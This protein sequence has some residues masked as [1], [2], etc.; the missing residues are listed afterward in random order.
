MAVAR[1]E[2]DAQQLL[3]PVERK[4][5][6]I[7]RVVRGRRVGVRRGPFDHRP[8][9]VGDGKAVGG[10]AVLRNDV[11]RERLAGPWI[12]DDGG[13]RREV[14]VQL[15]QGRHGSPRR[16]LLAIERLDL[17]TA[18]EEQA[19]LEQRAA[20]RAAVVVEV[21]LALDVV[22]VG[23]PCREV[24][25]LVE[26]FVA[27]GI[28][29][30][31]AEPVRAALGHD[32]DR[33]AGVAPLVGGEVRR[34]DGDLLDEVDPDVVDHAAVRPRVE[35]E[36][37]VDGQVVAVAA[38]AVDHG[39]ARAEA[40]G[41]RHLVVVELHGAGNERGQLEIVAARQRRVL[42]LRAVDDARDLSGGAV[43]GLAGYR[44][45]FD[46]LGQAADRQREV[47]GHAAVG[48]HREAALLGLAEAFELRGDLV[49]ANRKVGDGVSAGGRGDIRP[50]DASL[51]VRDGDRH[52]RQHAAGGIAHRS[53]DLSGVGLGQLPAAP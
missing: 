50:L 29:D 19:I 38:I 6:L 41:D 45:H 25:R 49:A 2:I 22:A 4:V 7:G 52:A 14:A 36:A 17:D 43:D 34:L 42:D 27:E 11:A 28:E 21:Q 10:D 12:A 16:V 33:G 39:P 35:V 8:I 18:E 53:G 44:C 40:G 37:A 5:E 31:A 24:V 51:G 13:P 47:S 48:D 9:G 15:R 46:G 1:T 26:R 20:E 30:A 3:V 32:V 23:I